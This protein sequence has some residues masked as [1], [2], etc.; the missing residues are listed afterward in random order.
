MWTAREL[1]GDVT[2]DLTTPQRVRREHST[3]IKK[4]TKQKNTQK[5]KNKT[6]NKLQLRQLV[7]KEKHFTDSKFK[8]SKRL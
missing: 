8:G 5:T 7:N 3:G 4:K 6:Q 1:E 2:A